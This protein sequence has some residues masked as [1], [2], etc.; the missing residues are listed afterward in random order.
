VAR[1][2]IEPQTLEKYL[3]MI[4]KNLRSIVLG[5]LSVLLII[6]SFSCKKIEE[7]VIIDDIKPKISIISPVNNSKLISSLVEVEWEIEDEN[8]RS[9]Y[10][11]INSGEF[12]DIPQKGKGIHDLLAGDYKLLLIANDIYLNTSKDSLVFTVIKDTISPIINVLSPKS[13]KI[14]ESND[15]VIVWEIE[16]HNFY[17]A[18]YKIFNYFNVKFDEGIIDKKTGQ[19]S[20]NIP[21]G[22]NKLII[23]AEDKLGN[24]ATDTVLLDI[25]YW[26]GK[27]LL[28]P[29]VQPNDSTLNWYGSGDVDGNNKVDQSDLTKLDQILAGTFVPALESDNPVEYRTLDRADVNGDGKVDAVDKQILQ[30]K[31]NGSREYLPGEW[32][33]LRTRTEREEWFQKIKKINQNSSTF[34]KID[35]S[36]DCNVFS[37]Q[38]LINFNGTKYLGYEGTIVYGNRTLKL[39]DNGRF[40]IPMPEVVFV[41]NNRDYAAH[42]MNAFMIGDDVRNFSDWFFFDSIGTFGDGKANEWA[43]NFPCDCT[44]HI[45]RGDDF[46]S[47]RNIMTYKIINNKERIYWALWLFQGIPQELA[48]YRVVVTRGEKI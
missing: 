19:I 38:A 25:R 29:F 4:N 16:E 32:N 43:L 31:L 33:K 18:W 7:E 36:D 35:G 24:T 23:G 6:G 1:K 26:T 40:N 15:I 9:A 12:I 34:P 14:Y 21:N 48:D 42:A 27:Y 39:K 30:E 3:I 37:W 2:I 45:G 11:K 47:F 20:K 13:D 10:Y 22:F 46:S 44:I 8:F 17:K 28:N 41:P 5:S